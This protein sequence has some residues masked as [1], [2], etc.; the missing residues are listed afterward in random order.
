M[1][2]LRISLFCYLFVSV[3]ACNENSEIGV[4]FFDEGS[5]EVLYVDSLS[6]KVSTVMLDS[7]ITNSPSRLLVGSNTDNKLGKLTAKSYFQLTPDQAYSIDK[8]KTTFKRVNLRLTYDSYSYYDTLIANALSVH[9]VTEEIVLDDGY[10]YN[11]HSFSYDAEA[12]G[13]TI[14]YPTPNRSDTLDI[15]L[16]N[17]F[18]QEI[19]ELIRTQSDVLSTNEKFFRYLPGLTIVPSG[20]QDGPIIGFSSAQLYVYY[21]DNTNVPSTE[22]YVTFS[23]GSNLSFNQVTADRS[24]TL[25]SNLLRKDVGVKSSE[26]DNISYLQSGTG[27]ALRVEIPYV[28]ELLLQN[29]NIIMSY[30]QLEMVPVQGTYNKNTALPITLSGYGVNLRNDFTST[31]AVASAQLYE[32]LDIGRNTRYVADVSDYVRQQLKGTETLGNAILFIPLDD[33]LRFSVTRAYI[34]DQQSQYKMKLKVYYV[35]AKD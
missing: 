13:S 31:S 10:L 32:D 9:S 25:L 17:D 8:D 33:E 12:L 1:T 3:C 27:L 5:L 20:G 4:D 34:G 29:S 19:F 30:A 15:A 2:L 26:T 6:L 7:M 24:S 14:F 11:N 22:E 35:E 28:K 23:I 16:S 21:L 18:G